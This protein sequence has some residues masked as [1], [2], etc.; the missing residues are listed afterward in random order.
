MSSQTIEAALP[1]LA[2]LACCLNCRTALHGAGAC[3]ACGRPHPQDNGVLE[4]IGPLEGRNR[5][6]AAFYDGPG[7]IRFRKWERL[8]LSVQ[9]G[10]KRARMSILRHVVAL[11]R[12]DAR[13]LEVGIGDG[14]NLRFLPAS[15]TIYGVDI[16]RTQLVACQQH[17]PQ[18]RGRLAWAE[19][20][21]L[22]FP[23]ETF[24][25]C[26]SI[27][28]FTYYGDHASALREMRRV[29]RAGGPVV[30]A[31]EAPG[32]HRAGLG[33]VVGFPS[34]DKAWLRL[35]GLD[36]AFI[37]MVWQYDVDLEAVTAQTWPDAAR[38]PIWMRLGYCLVNPALHS[39][40]GP[41]GIQSTGRTS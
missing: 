38:L 35:L 4:A 20:E 11:D 25:A 24:D 32:M 6:V 26:Y 27:G 31:D 18:L 2:D 3:P 30:V 7:W 14:E 41:I 13:V 40:S 1:P 39:L 10:A 23:D 12:P 8:F 33:H 37:D 19:A 36:T 5:I 16:A 28:G 21:R 9:G 17:H 22:P 29:T 34:F 15:W